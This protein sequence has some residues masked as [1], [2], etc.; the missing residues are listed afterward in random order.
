LILN[1]IVIVLLG[2]KLNNITVVYTPWSNLKKTNGMEVGQV[3]F[4]NP[5]LVK[6]YKIEKRKNEIVNRLNKTKKETNPDLKGLRDARDRAERDKQKEKVK[7][8]V[9][10]CYKS[11][12]ELGLEL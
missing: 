7:E 4:H 6:K 5:K 10:I 8:E 2:N 11:S 9:T 12:S 1:E 3:G